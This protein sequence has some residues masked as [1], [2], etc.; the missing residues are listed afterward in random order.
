MAPKRLLTHLEVQYVGPV[1]PTSAT[2][3][4]APLTPEMA[5]SIALNGWRTGRLRITE[6]CRRRMKER[7]FDVLDIEHV[8]KRGRPDGPAVKCGAPHENFKYCFTCSVDGA[9]LQVAFALDP[10]QDYQTAPLVI[11]ITGVW[12]TATGTKHL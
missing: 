5:R 3:A 4:Q 7:G 10:T 11:L 9:R 8:I 2:E 1:N 6:H 12:K